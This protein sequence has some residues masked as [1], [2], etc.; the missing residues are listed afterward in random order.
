MTQEQ[1][2]KDNR[3]YWNSKIENKFDEKR[4]AVESIFTNEI[5]ETATKK[6]P[7]FLKLLGLDKDLI[8][9]EKAEKAFCDYVENKQ[10]TE[11]QLWAKLVLTYGTLSKKWDR[12]GKVRGWTEHFPDVVKGKDRVLIETIHARLNQNCYDETKK[13]FYKSAKSKELQKIE[14]LREE[15]RDVLHSDMIGSEVLKELQKIC[16]QS[17]I[18]IS[19]PSDKTLIISQGGE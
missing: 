1:I 18:T 16:N 8:A 9:V 17:N 15:A 13:A 11:N 6:Y 19:I 3:I 7:K 4:Q 10:K 14:R 2:S 5:S 12:W